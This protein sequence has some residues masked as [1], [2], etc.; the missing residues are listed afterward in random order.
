M[1]IKAFAASLLHP[2]KFASMNGGHHVA[3]ASTFRFSSAAKSI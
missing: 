2:L 1:A 3:G